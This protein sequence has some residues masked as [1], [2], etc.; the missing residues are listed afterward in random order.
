ME[1]LDAGAIRRDYLQRLVALKLWHAWRLHKQG[2]VDLSTALTERVDLFRLSVFCGDGPGTEPTDAEGW[3]RV[4]LRCG[5]SQC[6]WSG[7]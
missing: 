7:R 3:R 4:L 1:D 6:T 5:C 2:Q